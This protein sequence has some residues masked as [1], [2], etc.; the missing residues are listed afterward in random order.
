MRVTISL[1]ERG[2]KVQTVKEL[3]GQ[4]AE[5]SFGLKDRNEVPSNVCIPLRRERPHPLPP[6]TSLYIQ[7]AGCARVDNCRVPRHN[8]A[9]QMGENSSSVWAFT[10]RAS[11][12]QL[13]RLQDRG[14]T[15]FSQSSR[16]PLL[17]DRNKIIKRNARSVF[18]GLI[19]G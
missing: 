5:K 15:S 18:V 19:F 11:V 4:K 6:P 16:S 17:D 8:H 12:P 13:N 1:K 9:S 14:Y 3:R 2:P 10:V 7:I